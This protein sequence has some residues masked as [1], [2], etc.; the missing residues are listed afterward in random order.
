M[1]F[2]G[3][4]PNCGAEVAAR[5]ARLVSLMHRI[6]IRTKTLSHGFSKAAALDTDATLSVTRL[7]HQGKGLRQNSLDFLELITFISY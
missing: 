1:C 7:K 5:N 3:E 4:H 2:I 6:K